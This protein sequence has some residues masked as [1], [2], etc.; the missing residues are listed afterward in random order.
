MKELASGQW[1]K[2]LR[3]PLSPKMIEECGGIIPV[4]LWR[5]TYSSFGRILW[6]INVGYD[7]ECGV[8][9]QIITGRSH[10]SSS[11]W[12]GLILESSVADRAG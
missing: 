5:A 6:Q 12:R 7:E 1:D 3:K 10:I 2:S 9:S 11:L 8:E 4:P